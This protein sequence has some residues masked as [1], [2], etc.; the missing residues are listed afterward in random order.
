MHGGIVSP[1]ETT[2]SPA[3]T[4]L[5]LTEFAQNSKYEPEFHPI[6]YINLSRQGKSEVE[7]A[8]SFEVGLNTMRNWGE[9]FEQ[10][11]IARDCGKAL[12][13]SWWLTV[14]KAGLTDARFFNT[15]LFKFLTGNKLGYSEAR[16]ESKNLN[17]NASG[18]LV[19]PTAQSEDEW[20]IGE[21]K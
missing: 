6:E 2:L 10:F 12:Y 21:S 5:Y 4:G 13:E 18:V 15:P 3:A 9:K 14:G 8:A 11:A 16:T 17:L 20:S 1:E 19:V 7:I